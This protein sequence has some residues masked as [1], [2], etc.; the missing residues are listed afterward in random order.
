MHG[1]GREWEDVSGFELWA[2]E[3]VKKRHWV[4]EQASSSWSVLVTDGIFLLALQQL[5]PGSG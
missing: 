2:A 3:Q 5:S 1:T 4:M